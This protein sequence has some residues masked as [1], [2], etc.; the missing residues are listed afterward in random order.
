VACMCPG[1]RVRTDNGNLIGGAGDSGGP[2]YVERTDGRVGAR[3]IYVNGV[4]GVAVAF[5][6]VAQ[7][8]LRRELS[9]STLKP[10]DTGRFSAAIKQ[11]TGGTR[12]TQPTVAGRRG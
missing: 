12:R 11:V 2:V 4:P 8:L 3:G 7:L 5:R 9:R 1:F 10:G 6:Y